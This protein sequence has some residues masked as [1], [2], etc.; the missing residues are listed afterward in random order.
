MG[1][2]NWVYTVTHYDK[3]NAWATQDVTGDVNDL[4]FDDIVNELMTAELVVDA[5]NGFYMRDQR[6]GE[7]GYPTKIDKQDRI[8]I[9]SVDG[10]SIDTYNQVFDVIK[11]TP[12]K[13]E[14]GGT[15]LKLKLKHF[16]RWL[17]DS[18]PFVGR[19]T[20]E[21]PS[22]M[23]QRLGIYYN[24][25]RG[26]DEPLLLG[27][28]TTDSSNAL[29]KVIIDH[30]DFGNNEEKILQRMRE[31]T[32]TMA[33][34]GA[35]G[36]VLDFFDFR[37]D[38]QAGNVTTVNIDVRSSGSRT[39]GSE[40]IINTASDTVV[41]SAETD[42]GEEELIGN[43]TFAW[44]TND[45]GSLPI[46]YSRFRSRQILLPTPANAL[47]AEWVAGTYQS[48]SIVKKAGVV[49]QANSTTS[50]TP[51]T[52]WTSLTTAS[53]YGNVIQY[54]PWT[55]D[56]V[57]EWKNS[58]GD[59]S[60]A[61]T[62]NY[63]S[64]MVDGN[65]IINDDTTFQTWADVAST[66]DAFSTSWKY[67]AN[68][69]GVYEGLRVLINGT[70]SAGF[71]GNDLEGRAFSQSIAEYVNGA[72]HVKYL[73][74]EDMFCYVF[75]EARLYQYDPASKWVNV[76][77]LDNGSHCSHPYISISNCESVFKD[78]NKVEYT[79]TNAS[80][81]IQI[82]YE[83]TPAAS[84]LQTAFNV[85]TNA[86]YFRGGAWLTLRFPFPKNTYNA[87]AE[88]LGQLYGG[89]GK[90][91]VTATA[92]VVGSVVNN[93]QVYYICIVAHTSG[94]FATDVNNR[95]WI[96]LD[97]KKPSHLDAQNMTYSH[98]GAQGFNFGI[99]SQDFG[100]INA[101]DF[102][103][104]L[105][106][107]DL[108]DVI[109]TKGNFK[110]RCW[111]ADRNDHVVYQDFVVTHN[112]NWQSVSLP[113]GGF[114]IY[115]G[116]KPSYDA[117]I[118]VVLGLNVPNGLDV[119]ESFE[120]RHVTMIGW[121]TQESYDDFGRYQAGL[122]DF[123][124]ANVFTLTSR[125]MKMYLDGLRFK[126]PLLV[127]TDIVTSNPKITMPFLEKKDI[128]IYDQLS[129]V[130]KAENEKNQFEKAMYDIE[131]SL[132]HDIKAGDFFYLIDPEIVD[133]QD[134]GADNKILLVANHIEYFIKGDGDDGG[135]TRLIHGARRF[136]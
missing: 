23:W 13:S 36:G 48:G 27:H 136:V 41:N 87:I 79:T 107:T 69:A 129:Q 85:R 76:T 17:E 86:D 50:S 70:G 15:L 95:K 30:F 43:V 3:S 57:N 96:T 61:F 9:I 65:V 128:I 81:S 37:I 89:G 101:L 88:D 74:Q 21:N 75:D 20:F 44:G 114:Q 63:G 127:G 78:E 32:E 18:V 34:T 72:W 6:S 28:L 135:A 56:K 60:D 38:A 71:A 24:S 7:S 22:N 52:G 10:G 66:T 130:C 83:W 133:K 42:G 111:M 97:G 104:K 125:R 84:W 26:T 102:F 33:A 120:W 39:S 90:N 118:I 126:K 132:K 110:M 53:Y 12:I 46:D 109:L 64:T 45:G 14:N 58:G 16:G 2:S 1:D 113:L 4:R 122:G 49:Y 94:T 98:N 19:G 73:P 35:D 124:V 51:P 40:V 25:N 29:P 99:S 31:L 106:Y 68:S 67:G 77:T 117:G 119:N 131:T 93:T 103:M 92:Y 116:R 11:K 62:G 55:D 8:R 115:R 91:W 112:N 54:S 105:K 5:N 100:Q 59:P 47:F 134:G 108:S 123:G 121:Q 82:T 80:S